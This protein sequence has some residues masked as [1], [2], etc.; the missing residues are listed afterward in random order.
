METNYLLHLELNGSFDLIDF[1]RHGLLMGE[2][3]REL[4]G[5]VQTGTQKTG[6]LFDESVRGQ[7]SVVL[8]R[9]LLHQFLVLVQ[10]LQRF[11]IHVRYIV[12]FGFVTVL[13]VTQY[14]HLHLGA[15]D[16]L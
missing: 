12:G 8:L 11:H 15:R 10:L 6:D 2:K 1:L 16:V 9:Q 13:L 4:A 5:F 7:E 3:T 14:A